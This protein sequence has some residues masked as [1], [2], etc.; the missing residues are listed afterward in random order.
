MIFMRNVIFIFHKIKQYL[1]HNND[2]IRPNR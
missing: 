1:V 2:E